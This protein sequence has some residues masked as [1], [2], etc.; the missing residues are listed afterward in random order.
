MHRKYEVGDV[1]MIDLA[2][3][4]NTKQILGDMADDGVYPN[5]AYK[6]TYID[7]NTH[8]NNVSR[9]I[10]IFNPEMTC[11]ENASGGWYAGRFK[12]ADIVPVERSKLFD[13]LPARDK[14][15]AQDFLMG[16]YGK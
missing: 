5:M 7:R 13:E 2:E 11:A 9:D 8:N 3:P 1:V 15:V 12:P 10:L 14:A 16:I 6:I 4:Q